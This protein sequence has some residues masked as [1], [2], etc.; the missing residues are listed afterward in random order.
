MSLISLYGFF[1][2]LG[3][4][5]D[6]CCCSCFRTYDTLKNEECFSCSSL[7]LFYL[8]L[9]LAKQLRELASLLAIASRESWNRFQEICLSSN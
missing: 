9:L 5:V 7:Q 1:C 2:V 3:I 6:M 8:L 4:S